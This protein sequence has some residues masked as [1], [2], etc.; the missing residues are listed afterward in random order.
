[1]R[2]H[3]RSGG[4]HRYVSSYG[5]IPYV[6]LVVESDSEARIAFVQKGALSAIETTL[7]RHGNIAHNVE[8]AI[9]ALRAL[10]FEQG[11]PQVK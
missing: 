7:I 10:C 9:E 6:V 2:G 4:E 1:M 3:C 8:C 5:R 11:T